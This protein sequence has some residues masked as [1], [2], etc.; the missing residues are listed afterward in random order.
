[1]RETFNQLIIQSISLYQLYILE[2][3]R[4]IYRS[5][6]YIIFT[7]NHM[8]T[9]INLLWGGVSASADTDGAGGNGIGSGGGSRGGGKSG[10]IPRGS[11]SGLKGGLR[12]S[13]SAGGGGSLRDPPKERSCGPSPDLLRGLAC[14]RLGMGE[15]QTGATPPPGSPGDPPTHGPATWASSPP[16]DDNVG[17]GDGVSSPK[18]P[19]SLSAPM[20]SCSTKPLTCRASPALMIILSCSCATLISPLYIKSITACTSQ[21]WKSFN[22][23]TGCLQGFSEKIRRKKGEHALSTTLWART[24]PSAHT[25]VTSTRASA[26][27]SAANALSKWCWW[28]FQRRL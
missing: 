7:T 21:P 27:R 20:A 3:H 12:T 22:T 1:M 4:I 9:I 6:R 25:R 17:S 5:T 24:R 10:L 14:L 19:P 2:V 16:S 28:L 13:F 8:K 26:L 18:L 23:M 15:Q 11:S